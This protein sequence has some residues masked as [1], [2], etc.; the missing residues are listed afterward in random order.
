[1]LHFLVD[2]DSRAGYLRTLRHALNS[3]GAIVIGT[4]AEDGPTQCSNLEVRHYSQAE[5]VELLRETFEPLQVQRITHQTPG[6]ATQPFNW[7]AG[8]ARLE[9]TQRR[10]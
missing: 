10:S 8:R 4:F 3:G 2:E 7:V 5:L 9:P 1:V 6:G